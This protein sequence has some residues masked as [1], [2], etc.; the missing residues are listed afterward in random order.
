MTAIGN[1]YGY[2]KLFAKQ[3]QAQGRKG[4]VFIGYSTSGKSPDVLHAFEE[5]R[6][7]RAG[8]QLQWPDVSSLRLSA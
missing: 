2:E 7:Y 8:W 5:A 3:V 6:L 1:D 4:D